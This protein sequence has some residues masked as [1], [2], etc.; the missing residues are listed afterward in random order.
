MKN[1]S[2]LH[3]NPPRCPKTDKVSKARDKNSQI[4]HQK[5][6]CNIPYHTL[7]QSRQITTTYT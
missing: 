7:G 1:W 6:Y 3:K 5:G 2:T 4:R